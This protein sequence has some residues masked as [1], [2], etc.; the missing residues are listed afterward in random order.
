VPRAAAS[1]RDDEIVEREIVATDTR[2]PRSEVDVLD[3]PDAMLDRRATEEPP[4]RSPRPSDAGDVLVEADALHEPWFWIHEHDLGGRSLSHEPERA[5]E[6]RV[7]AT[8]DEHSTTHE[9]ETRRRA[10]L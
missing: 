8:H 4:E 6:T 9:D 1:G 2:S 7:T 3:P 5:E 10:S